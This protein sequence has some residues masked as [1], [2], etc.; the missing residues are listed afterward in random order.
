MT[1]APG[2]ATLRP[3]GVR[4]CA[5]SFFGLFLIGWG[6]VE[7]KA[8][9]AYNE[10][11]KRF[12]SS[13]LAV[14]DS[15]LEPIKVLKILM[16]GLAP[17]DEAGLWLTNFRGI[18]VA[19]SHTPFDLAYLDA[20]N[21]VLQ[22]V[23]ITQSSRFVPF[24]GNPASAL[25]LRPRCLSSS[26]TFTGDRILFKDVAL[27]VSDHAPAVP[28][29]STGI[30]SRIVR[31]TMVKTFNVPEPQGQTAPR[32][33]PLLRSAGSLSIKPPRKRPEED[34]VEAKRQR[35]DARVA[36]ATADLGPVPAPATQWVAPPPPPPAAPAPAFEKPAP[37]PPQEEPATFN[38]EP[39]AAVAPDEQISAPPE[40]IAPERIL[41]HSPEAEAA[42]ESTRPQPE[43]FAPEP[44]PVESHA[45]APEPKL[46]QPE[47]KAPAESAAPPATQ[48]DLPA[49]QI[50]VA[51]WVEETPAF[52]AIEET[53][54]ATG[55]PTPAPVAPEAIVT[56][57][58]SSLPQ[59]I[60]T[61][62]VSA[63]IPTEETKLETVAP[64]SAPFEA[65]KSEEPPPAPP[66]E[67][68]KEPAPTAVAST[69]ALDWT[70]RHMA[71]PRTDG[72]QLKV[73]PAA[74]PAHE[75]QEETDGSEEPVS[76]DVALLISSNV[77]QA[78]DLPFVV[79][80][81]A[82]SI[83]YGTEV[84]PESPEEEQEEIEEKD[85]EAVFLRRVERKSP[86]PAE[87]SL[88]RRTPDPVPVDE[89]SAPVDPE[90]SP[91]PEPPALQTA[92]PARQSPVTPRPAPTSIDAPLRT[93][94][95]EPI[96]L[97]EAPRTSRPAATPARPTPPPVQET[98]RRSRPTPVPPQNALEP[99]RPVPPPP[100]ETHEELDPPIFPQS[101]PQSPE[102][103]QEVRMSLPPPRPE[104]P[105]TLHLAKRWDVKL[106]YSIFPD[107]HPEFRPELET[108]RI[109]F[110]K[111]A[112]KTAEENQSRKIKILNWLYPDLHLDTVK[113]RQREERR[114]PRIPVPGLVGYFF[115]GGKSEPHQI[116]NI[117]VMGFYMKTDQRWMPGTVIRVT[118]QMI[119]SDGSNPGDTITVLSRV[120]NWDDDGGGF[121]FVLPGFID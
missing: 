99:R 8:V 7:Q 41:A 76:R 38:A 44:V 103:Q 94:R 47:A 45:A 106:L 72:G 113:K 90:G 50:E 57:D 116:L 84:A 81:S 93:S 89:P 64:A 6:C 4:I 70:A 117:S 115:T 98:P 97:R 104:K 63:E 37:L 55:V 95:P 23:E 10:S 77:A 16:E 111:E 119:D 73:P 26:G 54:E 69:P 5:G 48:E 112:G 49:P 121:E 59:E 71:P 79:L 9:S 28:A 65:P 107:L 46:S 17:E 53:V 86:P 11:S 32:S 36:E 2:D 22:A 102:P 83:I 12:L 114:A 87:I 82:Q 85:D 18:P 92:T 58:T 3:A 1:L 35:L 66:V 100:I 40:P 80:A 14:V 15:A 43:E 109:D 88:T 56:A 120:V 78:A 30:F 110:L 75:S 19:R 29:A 108:P 42:A 24:K 33:G 52:A 105:E 74:P 118:L 101:T 62:P 20:E 21:R 68:A 91:S 13:A 31:A 60:E 67:I 61:A 39:A 51:S 25:I 96:P 34:D 27:E